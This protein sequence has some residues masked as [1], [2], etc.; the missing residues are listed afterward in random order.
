MYV[1][2]DEEK[3]FQKSEKWATRALKDIL[4]S[5]NS[6]TIY[7]IYIKDQN[8]VIRVKNLWIF[9][10]FKTKASINLLDYQ[11][12]PTFERILIA[13][14]EK[15][16]KEEKAI[17]SQKIASSQLGQKVDNTENAKESS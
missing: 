10:D 17:S 6:Y 12:K 7:K 8:K 11:N 9:E 4:V 15:N 1:F 5:Y 2:V 13:D 14:R 16:S 3:W